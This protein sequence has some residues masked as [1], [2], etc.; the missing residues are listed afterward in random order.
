MSTKIDLK[1]IERRANYAVFQDGLMEVALG[2][3]LFLWGGIMATHIV[4][5]GMLIV[6]LT[7]L[8]ARPVLER[9]KQHLI[10]PRV[11]YVRLP[12]DPQATG[13]G[14]AIAAIL[15]IVFLL[16]ALGISLAVLGIQA[17]RNF[18]L[19]YILPPVSGFMLAIGPYWLG[20]TYG[21]RRG[22]LWAVLFLLGGIALPV[23]GIASGYEA[24]GW[25]C[26]VM[27]LLIL[28]TGI[29][30][31]MRFLRRYPPQPVET[32]EAPHAS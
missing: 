20:R 9:V 24:V 25:L 2:L 23:L 31:F 21:L 22:Y 8:F 15:M 13:K 11:G 6:I 18:F 17:G 4:P 5:L 26:T 28:L 19:A 14:I 1:E 27:G 12:G 32:E 3:F 10:Y 7:I 29:I 16:G 30:M